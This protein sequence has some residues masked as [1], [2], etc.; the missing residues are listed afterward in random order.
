MRT[1]KY[2]LHKEWLYLQIENDRLMAIVNHL[3]L[4]RKD[5]N[6]CMRVAEPRALPLGYSAMHI[7]CIK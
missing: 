7:L 5:S 3:W 6:F 1:Q 2:N 4:P